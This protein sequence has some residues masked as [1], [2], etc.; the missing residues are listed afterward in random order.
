MVMFTIEPRIVSILKARNPLSFKH[1][2]AW[3]PFLDPHITIPHS[4]IGAHLMWMV[5]LD[6]RT[7]E[8][9]TER[10]SLHHD[11]RPKKS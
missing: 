5:E 6:P 1:M 4:N 11:P 8:R 2:F 7:L 9:G 10:V 3:Y